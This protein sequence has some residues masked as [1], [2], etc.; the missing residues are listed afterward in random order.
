MQLPSPNDYQD[1]RPYMNALL[2]C[3]AGGGM[4]QLLSE[5]PF[6]APL[7]GGAVSTTV[8][9]V[10]ADYNAVWLSN[11]DASLYIGNNSYDPPVPLDLFQIDTTKLADASVAT[12]KLVDGAVAT[13][14]IANLAVG[15]AQIADAAVLSAKIGDAQVVTAKI[16]DAAI[17]S[18]KIADAQITSAK[19]ANLAV[20]SAHIQDAAI[21][22]AKIGALAVDSAK[23]AAAAITTAKIADAQITTAKIGSAQI[24]QALM[25]NASIGTA[26]IID[27]N[28]TTAK[29][30]DLA[31]GSAKIA[32][33]AITTAKIANLAVGTAQIAAA[34]IQSAKIDDLAV[35]TLK[36]NGYAVTET[37][38]AAAAVSAVGGGQ[39]FTTTTQTGDGTWR[40]MKNSLADMEATITTANITGDQRVVLSYY[41]NAL[42]LTDPTVLSFRVLRNGSDISNYVDVDLAVG[43]SA[44]TFIF[45]DS[46]PAANTTYTYTLQQAADQDWQKLTAAG[47]VELFKR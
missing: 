13:T 26:Q 7:L 46:A 30:A 17:N 8:A 18:A 40:D 12:A 28:I 3:L 27:A 24:T 9:Q 14:K 19:I 25:A 31:V 21:T 10:P 15:T 2:A 41:I 16:A 20:G 33:A 23:I 38:L 11:T 45:V 36:I 39:Y 43:F 37:K 1:W 32:D 4:A 29:I 44:L 22:N 5:D 6:T 34:A 35:T 42:Q 47:I